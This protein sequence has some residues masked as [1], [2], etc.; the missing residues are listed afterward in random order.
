MYYVL[1]LIAIHFFLSFE[2]MLYW[3]AAISTS[4]VLTLLLS[5]MI[6]FDFKITPLKDYFSELYC[7]FKL[8][9]T[10]FVLYFVDKKMN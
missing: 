7:N 4:V 8:F 2:N 10:I 6:P 5:N 1:N 9:Y 3:T